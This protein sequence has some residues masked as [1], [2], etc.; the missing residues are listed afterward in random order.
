MRKLDV[1]TSADKSAFTENMTV[2]FTGISLF[3]SDWIIH[4]INLIINQ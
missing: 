2:S 1:V 3:E 4:D